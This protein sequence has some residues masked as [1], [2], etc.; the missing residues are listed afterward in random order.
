MPFSCFTKQFD[1]STEV[2]SKLHEFIVHAFKTYYF[3]PY[4]Y[5]WVKHTSFMSKCARNNLGYLKI[6]DDFQII[7]NHV[8]AYTSASVAEVESNPFPW[9]TLLILISDIRLPEGFPFHQFS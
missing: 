2:Y 5:N 1:I 4:T 3:L 9:R 6:D 8:N 7:L